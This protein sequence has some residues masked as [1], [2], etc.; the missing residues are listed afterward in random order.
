MGSLDDLTSPSVR[1]LEYCLCWY[2]FA[3][4]GDVRFPSLN[5]VDNPELLLNQELKGSIN[6]A[7]QENHIVA[8]LVR[9]CCCCFFKVQKVSSSGQESG[10]HSLTLCSNYLS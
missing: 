4:N 2:E 10:C 9:G 7:D 6:V 8:Y 3:K 1:S 5:T